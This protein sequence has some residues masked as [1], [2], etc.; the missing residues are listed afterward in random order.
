MVG[1]LMQLMQDSHLSAHLGC[2]RKN[3]I[4][5]IV[6]CDHLRTA[7]SKEDASFLDALQALHIETGITLQGI[8]QSCTVLGKGWRIEDDEIIL[9][10]SPGKL[11]ATLSLVS[12][13]ALALLSTE[14]TCLASPRMA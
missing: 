1:R 12:S 10:A 4:A 14:C 5:E 11:S 3:S 6:L 9:L 2:S 13:M 8:A 7:E